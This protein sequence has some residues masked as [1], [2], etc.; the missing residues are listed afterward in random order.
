MYIEYII[1]D[2]Q[3]NLPKY[4]RQDYIPIGRKLVAWVYSLYV[5]PY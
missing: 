2:I 4:Q 5:T 3:V 1:K